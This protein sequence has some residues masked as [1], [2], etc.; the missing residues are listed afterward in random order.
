ME[1]TTNLKTSNSSKEI[2]QANQAETPNKK[3]R[4]ASVDAFRG[5][6]MLAM[7]FVIQVAGYKDLPFAMSWFGSPVVS[8]FHHAADAEGNLTGIGL[9]FTD[10]VAPFFVFIV[11]LVIPFSKKS[12]SGILW[13]KHVGTR[14]AMLIALGVIYISLILG[15]SYWWGILQ[16]IAIAYLMGAAFMLL[17]PNWRWVAIFVVAAFH[18]YMSLTFPWWTHLGDPKAT[19]LSI[20]NLG[21]DP[22]LPLTV[23]CTPWASISY[24]IITVT[25]TLL[26]EAILSHST[27]KIIT[28]S[29]IIGTVFC[30]AGYILHLYSWPVFAMNKATVSSSYALFT[31]GIGAFTFLIFFLIMDVAQIQAWAYPF[32]VFGSN[33]LL[34]YFLQPFVRMF[35]YAL[36]FKMYLTGHTGWMGM[37][38]GLLWTAI[39]WVVLLMCNKRNIYWKI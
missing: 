15:L 33:A 4:I 3:K 39:L 28:Q 10:L 35:L 32:I 16:A 30:L 26:G 2:K 25:G 5:F 7:I 20:A 1:T 6:T 17:K 36:G 12:R 23:H 27:K 13:W 22:W 8:T 37:F 31:S 18:Q 19:A 34:G 11:G 14:V 24:G 9:T 38:V 29:I 21:G